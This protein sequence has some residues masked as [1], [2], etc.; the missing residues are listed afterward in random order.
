MA[1]IATVAFIVVTMPINIVRRVLAAVVVRAVW[2]RV[3][4][5]IISLF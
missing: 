1:L 2:A 3:R 4:K 5:W